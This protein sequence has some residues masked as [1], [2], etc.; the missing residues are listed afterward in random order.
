MNFFDSIHCKSEKHCR[1]CRKKFGG[2]AMRKQWA[3][4]FNIAAVDFD[5]PNGK[6][7]IEEAVKTAASSRTAGTG[8]RATSMPVR[9]KCRLAV[10]DCCGKPHICSVDGGTCPDPFNLECLRNPEFNPLP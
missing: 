9:D 2:R 3:A 1:V 6:E 8:Y 4:L 7:W 10:R 5:C